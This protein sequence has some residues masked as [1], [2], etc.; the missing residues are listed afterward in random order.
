MPSSSNSTTCARTHADT[1]TQVVLQALNGH[2]V[3]AVAA[4]DHTIVS[5]SNGE[6]IG[7]GCNHNGQLGL[8]HT[9][10]TADFQ[11]LPLDSMRADIRAGAFH[12]IALYAGPHVRRA[13][14]AS[15]AAA[16]T[17]GVCAVS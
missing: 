5:L 11:T 6:V 15:A 17:S 8:G 10:M 4:S 3:T 13:K 1:L 14:N 7:C 9:I 12:S 16:T 2:Q